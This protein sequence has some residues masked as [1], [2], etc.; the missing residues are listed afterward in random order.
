[1]SPAVQIDG[2]HGEGG[3][4]ILRTALCLSALTGRPFEISDIRGGR[5]KP[6]LR[7]QHLAVVRAMATVFGARLRGDEIGSRAL[8]FAPGSGSAAS[9]LHF[10]IAAMSGSASA[11]SVTLLFQTLFPVLA[12]TGQTT[13]LHLRGGTH[14]RWSPAFH[15]LT[16]VYLPFMQRI[17][18]EATLDLGTWGWYPRGGGEALAR[19]VGTEGGQAGLRGVDVGTR[20]RLLRVWGIS[21]ASNLPTHVAERQRDRAIQR[22]RARHLKARIETVSAP[23]PGPGTMLLV[24]AGYEHIVA[25]FT[26]YGRLRYPAEKVADDAMDAF[27]EHLG[28]KMALDPFLADQILLPLALA[29]EGS[30]YT[31]SR[32]T[33]HLLTMI[34]SVQLFLDR[35]IIVAGQQGEPGEVAIRE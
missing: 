21:A 7:P 18:L 24:V 32:I 22:L 19:I 16:H 28:S 14:V 20:G 5:D 4:Q 13:T 6:G 25:G 30:R 34:W 2:A 26:G 8:I 1:M 31:T 27:E 29:P 23:S 10:D 15:Y 17:G 11:G 3:G 35:D 12:L 33:R 9:D